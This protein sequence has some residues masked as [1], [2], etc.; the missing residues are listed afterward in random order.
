MWVCD[1]LPSMASNRRFQLGAA[2]A[3][4]VGMIA[5]C[6]GSDNPASPSSSGTVPTVTVTSSGFSPT[7]V[8][9]AVDGQVRFV[10]NDSVN[11]QINSNPFPA[12]GDC[13]PINEVDLLTPGQS[14]MT[15]P[16]SFAGTCG[17]HEHFTEGA[18]GFLGVILV[19]DTA[20]PDDAAPTGY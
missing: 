16:L 15:G 1:M 18:A 5:A 10:N 13:P 7:E 4:T 8:R 9:I 2:F 6:G 19:G 3:V 20:S 11:R 17:F 12:H 14:K